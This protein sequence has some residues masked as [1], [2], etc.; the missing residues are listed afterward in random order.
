MSA[1]AERDLSLLVGYIAEGDS[2]DKAEHVLAKLT[3]LIE[4]LAEHA[5]RG[6][7]VN[8]LRAIGITQYQQLVWKPYRVVYEI[9]GD[10]VF[11]MV[12]ADGRRDMQT[13]LQRRLLS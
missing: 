2:L 10:T 5:E 7:V 11:V 4:S 12:V 6:V 8:E 13:L 3:G 9:E 1:S